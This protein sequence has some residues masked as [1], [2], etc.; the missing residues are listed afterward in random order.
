MLTEF[1]KIVIIT[2]SKKKKVK[3]GGSRDEKYI[4]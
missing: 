2:F 4:I 3:D 1:K